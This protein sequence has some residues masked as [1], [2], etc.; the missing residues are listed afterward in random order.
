MLFGLAEAPTTFQSYTNYMLHNY[1][2]VFCIAY[3]DNIHIYSYRK[4]D[5]M[6]HVSKVLKAILQHQLFGCLNKC[7]FHV[8]KVGFV[9]FI[10]TPG[11]ITIEPGKTS[12]IIDW[13]EPK[14]H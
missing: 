8:K 14:R 10:V 5:Y 6:A 3:L 13:P 1:L 12:C 2:D 4:A 9:G 11:G 7:K